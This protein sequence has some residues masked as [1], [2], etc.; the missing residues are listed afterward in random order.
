MTYYLFELLRVVLFLL[1]AFGVL[2]LSIINRR[3]K[4]ALI[5]ISIQFFMR[6]VLLAIQVISPEEYKE[7]NNFVATPVTAIM[8]LCIMVNVYRVRTD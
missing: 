4:L 7:I 6:A 1:C 3:E 8:L 2:H 5:A